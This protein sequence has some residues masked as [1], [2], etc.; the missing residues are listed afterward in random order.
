M[1][2]NQ[3]FAVKAKLAEQRERLAEL[4]VNAIENSKLKPIDPKALITEEFM[5]DALLKLKEFNTISDIQLKIGMNEDEL[6]YVINSM[7]EKAKC[8]YNL[9]VDKGCGSK[10]IASAINALISKKEQKHDGK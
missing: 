9:F 6:F 3:E 4:K 10:G 7:L 5:I 2:K 8:S 1:S